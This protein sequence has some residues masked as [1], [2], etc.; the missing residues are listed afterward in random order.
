MINRHCERSEAMTR[1]SRPTPNRIAALALSVALLSACSS[2]APL[3]PYPLAPAAPPSVKRPFAVVVDPPTAAA[4]LDSDR[5]LVKDRGDALV[6]ADARWPQPLPAMVAARVSETIASPE[7]P[8][9]VRLAL[10]IQHFE[11]IA[12]RKTV[13]IAIDATTLDA[14]SGAPLRQRTFSASASVPTTRPAD[15][16]AGFEK[17]FAG[18][19]AK[20]AAFAFDP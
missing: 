9:R 17:A 3:A 18:V 8:P 6:L 15:V 7:G 4:N 5:I 16:V 2:S 1:G 14:A 11:L 12:E 20:V 10:A 19:Q 13:V